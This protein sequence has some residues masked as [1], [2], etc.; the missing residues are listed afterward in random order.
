M[1]A[2]TSLEVESEVLSS[3]E[4]GDLPTGRPQVKLSER[5]AL[6]ALMDE[7]WRRHFCLPRY[8]P[9]KWWECDLFEITEAGYMREYEVKLS[10]ADFKNDAKKRSATHRWNSAGV[11]RNKY[12]CLRAGDHSGPTRFNYVTSV[13]LLKP[14]MI[15]EF[16]GLIELSY[17]IVDGRHYFKEYVIKAAP[18]LHAEYFVKDKTHER[19]TCYYRYHEMRHK[20]DNP[21]THGKE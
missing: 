5:T 3:G 10:V 1:S 14:E 6:W 17:V 12:E 9:S 2:P 15:P 19:N 16:A 8:T 11:E 4:V 20:A 18:V 13:G 7:R 21:R